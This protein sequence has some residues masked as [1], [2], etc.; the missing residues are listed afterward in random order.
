MG[1][2]QGEYG[3]KA[4]QHTFDVNDIALV[5]VGLADGL[6]LRAGG[7]EQE[8]GQALHH[9]SHTKKVCW[10]CADRTQEKERSGRP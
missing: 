1:R 8:Q 3:V 7:A 4:R 5:D 2:C 6:G 9:C 10:L